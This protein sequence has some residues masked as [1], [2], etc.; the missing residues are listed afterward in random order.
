MKRSGLM[1]E[2]TFKSPGFFEREIDLTQ[3][4]RQITGVPAGIAGTS[5]TGPAFVPVTVGSMI[6]FT[7]KFGDLNSEN[8]APYAVNEFLK[9]RTAV[10]Y[11][12]VLG[13]G[14][15]ASTTDINVTRTQGT[16]KNAG[17][18]IK[19]QAASTADGRY[20]G[21]VQ[22][23]AATHEVPTNYEV[24]GYPIFTDNRSYGLS[25]GGDVHL[26]RAMVFT[27]SGSRLEITGSNAF[28]PTTPGSRTPGDDAYISAYNG[29]DTQGTFKLIV[30]SAMGSNFASDEGRAGI[31]IY[32]ASLD[33][34]SKFYIGKILNKDPSRFS[35]EQHLLY[36]DFPVESEV[37]KVKRSGLKSYVCLVSGSQN[38]SGNSGDTSLK[39]INTFGKFDT[40][41]QPARTTNF[42]SQ[43]YGSSEYDL[44]YLETISDGSVINGK[45]KI[46]IR[47]VKKSTNPKT[48]YGTFTLEIRDFNDTDTDTKILES[49]PLCNL[50]PANENFVGKKIGDYKV[51]YNFDA[52]TESERRLVV[53]G[54]HPNKSSYVRIVLSDALNAGDIPKDA[55]P[56]GFRGLPV[57]KTNDTLTDDN[58]LGLAGIGNATNIKP[59]L[60][61]VSGSISV[62]GSVIP[63]A[64]TGSI[65]PPVP[66]RFKSTRGAV[67]QS[68]SPA[69]IG[70]PGTLELADS[71]YYWGIKFE[72]LPSTASISNAVLQ[73]NAS[74]TPN[75]L[76]SSYSKFLGI[77]KLDALVTG[78]GAD[79]FNDNKFTLARVA[80]YNSITSG[81]T[82][83]AAIEA[84]ITGSAATHI[85]EAAYLRDK[86]PDN[87]NYSLTDGTLSRLSIAS[88]Y[89]HPTSHVYFNRFVD[90]N[91]FTNM[92]Y[93]GFDGN[94]ILDSDMRLMN[95]R[96]ASSDAASGG[97]AAGGKNSRI[98]LSSD[99]APG[100]GKNNN[101]VAA[102]RAAGRILTDP[103]AS[104]VNII[105][106]PGMRDSFV[107]DYIADRTRDYSKGFYIMDIPQ[108][109]NDK[110]IIFD[111]NVASPDVRTTAEQFSA[112]NIDNS[113]AGAY[114]PDVSISD[115]INGRAAKVP[116]SV[117][118]VGAL[119]YTDAVAYPWFAPAGFNRGALESVVNTSTRL[120]TS[121]RDEL[122]EN[123]INPIANFPN[124]GFVIFGQKTLQQAQSALDRVNVRRMLIEV[125]RLVSDVANK[126]VFDQNTPST[127]TKFVAQVTPLLSII[128]S[129]QGIDQFKVVMDSSNNSPE[130]VESNRLNGRIVLVPTR[131]VEF[132]AIDFIITNSGV[133]FD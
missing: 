21:A 125:K 34:D 70:E 58:T 99:Y 81:Q 82:L 106:V 98:N 114:F 27:A 85:R 62:V 13:A 111:G 14:S 110:K 130:D 79:A 61:L 124:G 75:K 40:R 116:A 127:R 128:Q 80:L 120:T 7:K 89:A 22:F 123:R 57:I 87:A 96:A 45:F 76:I 55:L 59:R 66:L 24:A 9:N 105:A 77:S 15:N 84:T 23:I 11:I 18:I 60:G 19:G 65:L 50:N 39:F 26:I 36:A 94:N 69:F 115:P 30:S 90:Y 122:Y 95:D 109:S 113:Y 6:D 132:I 74:S 67:K 41:Y 107:T 53:E 108:Y 51:F 131:A 129:Q 91:K 2:Q 37:A 86:D 118:V 52:E 93:G 97:K 104:R 46:S 119:G 121:E 38:T 64:L 16:V 32:T 101:T 117:V 88:L 25:T 1:A 29:S 102:Y 83:Q 43:P 100:V 49:F 73:S 12:R 31:K 103:M 17:F 71:R 78:S 3:R 56:F 42:I 63:A 48:E 28:Y 20:K 5:Q 112:R 35:A 8:F 68:S 126:I 33:P 47:D 44:F 54:S 133:S 92:M 4:E 72:R 10:T